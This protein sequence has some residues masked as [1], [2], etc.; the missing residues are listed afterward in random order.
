[1]RFGP[2]VADWG[3]GMSVGRTAG[4]TVCLSVFV[5]MCSA[6]DGCM[7]V[8]LYVSISLCLCLCVVPM[9]AVCLSVSMYLSLS[10]YLYLCVCVSV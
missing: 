8:C 5:S 10:M 9:M 1:M 6:N 2:S 3:G 4:P 7:S